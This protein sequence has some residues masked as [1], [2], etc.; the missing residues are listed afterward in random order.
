LFL[1]SA[2]YVVDKKDV[3]CVGFDFSSFLSCLSRDVGAESSPEARQQAA[4]KT[5]EHVIL[6]GAKDLLFVCF[7]LR[8]SRCFAAV[9]MTDTLFQQ[10]ASRVPKSHKTPHKLP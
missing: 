8:N 1:S 6:S 10:P 4:E 9:S 7:Q 2:S 5:S 3:N